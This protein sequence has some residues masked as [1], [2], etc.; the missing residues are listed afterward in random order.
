[1]TR[2]EYFEQCSRTCPDLG[3]HEKNMAH[4][5]SGVFT[6]IGELIDI[7]KKELAYK[8]EIDRPNLIE[9]FG[10]V[11]WYLF[12]SLRFCKPEFTVADFNIVQESDLKMMETHLFA[13]LESE[14]SYI[15]EAHNINVLYRSCLEFL[16]MQVKVASG[17]DPFNLRWVFIISHIYLWEQI[18]KYFGINPEEAYEKNINKLKVRFPEK[19]SEEKALERDLEAERKTLE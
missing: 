6:E 11:C 15:S 13:F 9:E 5:F 4:M 3:S 18:M 17:E 14:T 19:F 10:D 1:M 12:N 2:E 16:N 7:Y 8:R